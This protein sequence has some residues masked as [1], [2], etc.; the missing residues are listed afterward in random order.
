MHFSLLVAISLF[1]LLSHTSSR[2]PGLA[3]DGDEGSEIHIVKQVGKV[4]ALKKLVNEQQF[5][6][7]KAFI[8][9]CGMVSD[10]GNASFNGICFVYLFVC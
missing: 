6:F 5:D 4:A 9:H 10:E 8:S 7:E 2:L 3:V 1:H